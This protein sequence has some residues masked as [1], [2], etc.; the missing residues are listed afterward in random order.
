MS[1]DVTNVDCCV[2]PRIEELRA[3]LSGCGRLLILT[4]DNPDPD[5]LASAYGLLRL[6]A[7][8]DG[9]SARIGFGGFVGRAEN[10]TM[11]RELGL[12]IIPTWAVGFDEFD[13]VA[14]VDTQPATGNNSL[15][16]DREVT[17]VI[18]HHPLREQTRKAR[19]WEVRTDCGSS[20]TII[21]QYL[22]AAGV[23]LE[24]NLA[25]ALFYGI[26]S[27]TQDLGREA[28]QG[29]I[30]ASLALY[31]GTD[32]ELISRIRYPSLP[33]A[34]FRTLHRS[35]ERSRTRGP[36][37]V[38]Y[39][40]TLDY[41]DLVAELADFYLRLDGA[42]WS[43]CIGRFEEDILISIRTSLQ[44]AFAGQLLRRVVGQDGSA[45]GHGMMAGARIPVGHMSAEDARLK[46][47]ELVNRFI[48]ELGVE[49]ETGG[50]LLETSSHGGA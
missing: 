44:D 36:V 32:Q 18:D 6:A 35:L 19:F 47:E 10:R 23:P 48:K 31:P 42:D 45:G 1:S 7:S 41:P 29:D 15:P 50:A 28:G 27:E 16:D 9:I 25:T 40:G 20:S 3:A 37:V 43:F 22:Q 46:S 12:P 4:H 24:G 34:Y 13:S 21:T 30:E 2:A 39:V 49:D 38:S 14:L 26:Q 33:R 5:S 11:V 8:F 17:L